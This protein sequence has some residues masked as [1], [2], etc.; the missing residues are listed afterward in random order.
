MIIFGFKPYVTLMAVVAL[1]CTRCH[2]RAAHRVSRRV[3]KLT[4]FFI[5]LFMVSRKYEM[6]CVACA[7]QSSLTESEVEALRERARQQDAEAAAR[8]QTTLPP[9]TLPPATLP[10]TTLPPAAGPE[11]S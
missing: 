10:P 1:V 11:H 2:N 5:P 9:A 3:N 7:A 6:S 8:R 4:I